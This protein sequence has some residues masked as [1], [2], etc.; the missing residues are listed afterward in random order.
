MSSFF[1]FPSDSF[2]TVSIENIMNT[3]AKYGWLYKAD[4]T[5]A[6][7]NAS[8]GTMLTSRQTML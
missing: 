2:G 4:I 5:A 8:I 1:Q 7:M 6:A 3:E